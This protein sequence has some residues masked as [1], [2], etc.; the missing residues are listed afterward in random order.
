MPKLNHCKSAS[1]EVL[2]CAEYLTQKKAID[3]ASLDLYRVMQE[4]ISPYHAF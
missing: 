1:Y 2:K 4:A 3:L